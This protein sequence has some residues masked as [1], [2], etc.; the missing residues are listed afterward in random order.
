MYQ[1]SWPILYVNI[2]YIK[3]LLKEWYFWIYLFW[4]VGG[5]ISYQRS[6]FVLVTSFDLFITTLYLR[7]YHTS[8]NRLIK[9]LKCYSIIA[10]NILRRS[11]FQLEENMSN[12][13][14]VK[15]I[16]PTVCPWHSH[17]KSCTKMLYKKLSKVR[18]SNFS[19]HQIVIQLWWRFQWLWTFSAHTYTICFKSKWLYIF[20]RR[21]IS[22]WKDWRLLH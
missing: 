12:F 3:N 17:R 13:W 9:F 5:I 11:N 6:R 7:W 2:D 22:F 16:S 8:L 10:K 4:N 14:Q 21:K 18:K 1:D 19:D 20:T 15:F